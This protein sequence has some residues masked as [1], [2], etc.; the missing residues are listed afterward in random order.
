[1]ARTARLGACLGSLAAGYWSAWTRRGSPPPAPSFCA[2][3]PAHAA[4]QA[5]ARGSPT[6][7]PRK[8]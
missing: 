3:A 2:P 1:M 7:D 6:C 4:S 5:D 8:S